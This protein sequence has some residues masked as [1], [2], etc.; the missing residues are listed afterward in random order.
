MAARED[1]GSIYKVEVDLNATSNFFLA[2]HK[3]R[4]EVSSSNFPRWDRNLN[5]GGNNFD[6]TQWLTATNTVH[7]P[8]AYPSHIL[9]PVVT[10]QHKDQ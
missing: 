2:G 3:I 4:I 1:G 9:L 7:H 5:T 8:K 6:E 10:D